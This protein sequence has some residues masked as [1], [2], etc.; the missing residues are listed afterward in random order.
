MH[1]SD[2]VLPPQIWISGYAITGAAV[3]YAIAKKMDVEDVPKVA[4]VTAA[5]FVASLVHVPVG[6]TCAHFMLNGLAGIILGWRALPGIFV[7]L[8]LQALLLQHG[9]LTTIGVNTI[10]MGVPALAAYVIFRY[11]TRLE[12]K[13]KYTVFGGLAGGVAVVL[14]T[15][16]L[17]LALLTIGGDPRW[18]LAFV[19]VPH[20]AIMAIEAIAAG[21]FAQFVSK[22]KP[23]MLQGCPAKGVSG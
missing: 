12:F 9:G 4:V 7:A 5:V 2:G 6:P 8:A 1:I 17:F 19:V 21:A 22:V 18:I 23:E 11:G 10:A 3:S 13:W 16:L 20:M 14:T 15:L